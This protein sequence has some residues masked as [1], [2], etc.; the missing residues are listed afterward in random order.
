MFI[1]DVLL[2]RL[3]QKDFNKNP[4]DMMPVIA[5]FYSYHGWIK[6]IKIRLLLGEIDPV[7][8]KSKTH[9]LNF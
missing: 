6:R 4:T 2:F 1:L 7:T 8:A 5:T 3:K 9:S